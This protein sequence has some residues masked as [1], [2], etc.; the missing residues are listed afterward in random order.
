M[1]LKPWFQL[2][3]I[4]TVFSAMCNAYAGYW[5]GEGK[6][7]FSSLIFGMLASGL[8]LMAG[9]IL[10][11]IAD[12]HEDLRDRPQRPLP[13]GAISRSAAWVS[14]LTMM[15]LGLGL[16]GLANPV[17]T[18][19]GV[20]LIGA[21]FAYNFI[22]KNTVIGPLSMGLC[23]LL[24]LLTGIALGANGLSDLLYLPMSTYVVLGLL[25]FYVACV[26][27][28]A[29]EETRGNSSGRI[30]VFFA[31]LALWILVWV[32]FALQQPMMNF[33][34]L[35]S[36][37]LLLLRRLY[38]PLKKL[39]QEPHLPSSTQRSVGTLLGCLPLADVMAMFLSGVAWPFALAGW[40][41]TLPGPF[42][43]KR[44]YST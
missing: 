41:F 25:G 13:S 14:A 40:I 6:A 32:F 27:F 5:I 39:W 36:I 43:T 10:N 20:L 17:C 31:G 35:S 28:L 16:Q 11:D 18:A 44:F 7:G 26:T 29:R 42:L 2:V 12:F 21:I 19:V 24:N 3:R 34:L 33:L 22:L 4:P 23:R 37:L 38:F 9:M 15:I 30:K 8:F 1:Q